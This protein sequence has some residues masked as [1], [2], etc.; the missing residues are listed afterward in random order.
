MSRHSNGHFPS[1][2][3]AGRYSGM[4][5]RAGTGSTTGTVYAD[6]TLIR[7]KIKIKVAGFLNFRK[8]AK[9]CTVMGSFLI[10]VF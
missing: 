2:D 9:P 10:R 7:S 6:I 4:V 8:L 5:R 1:A 3:C